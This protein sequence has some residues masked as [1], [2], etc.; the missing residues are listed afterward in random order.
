MRRIICIGSRY[1]PADAV[2]P[3]VY[4]RLKQ[5]SLP[6]NVEVVDGGLGGLGLLRFLEGTERVVFVDRV[7]GFGR[8]NEIV[9][10]GEKEVAAL[11]GQRCDHSAGLAY[12]LR[13]LPEVCE[14]HLPHVLLV[15]VEGDPDERIVGEATAL[16]LKI[17][18]EDGGADMLPT[19]TSTTETGQTRPAAV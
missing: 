12:L 11:A 16:A 7:C 1:V 15:G 8:P 13:V 2:G 3:T 6:G 10:L 17:A 9:V 18:A 5:T 19:A 4:D 14:G